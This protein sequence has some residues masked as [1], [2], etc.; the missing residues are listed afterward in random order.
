MAGG[1]RTWETRT[2]KFSSPRPEAR[3]TAIAMAGAV[4]SK[5]TPRK[6]TWAPGSLRASS[7]AS[8]G[9]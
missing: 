5:P 7:T 8:I 6:T 1:T 9:E 4:V 3:W 2:E